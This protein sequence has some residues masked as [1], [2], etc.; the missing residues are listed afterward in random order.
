MQ[1]AQLGDEAL[2]RISTTLS[3]LYFNLYGERPV[4]A[5]ASLTGNMLA[6][7]FQ[8]GL[9]VSDEWLLRT[10]R[11][12]QLREFRQGFFEVVSDEV[13]GVIGDLT[14][15]PVTYSFYGF[16]PTTRTTHSI[17]I[18][19]TSELGSPER[20]QAVLNWSEQVRRNARRLRKEHRETRDLH[21]ELKRQMWTK[22][23]EID[24]AEADDGEAGRSSDD[25]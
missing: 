22:R 6:H 20:R 18:L 4:D 23:E 7:V 17:F 25:P 3:D 12:E 13:V 15:M 9:A 10:G 19:D 16:D 2:A 1:P 11:G 8:G 21:R 24:R 14:G 5:R